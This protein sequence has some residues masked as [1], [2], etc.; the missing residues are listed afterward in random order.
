MLE[1]RREPEIRRSKGHLHRAGSVTRGRRIRP[2]GVDFCLC[3]SEFGLNCRHAIDSSKLR[4][5]SFRERIHPPISQNGHRTQ[6]PGS[7]SFN[8][9][10]SVRQVGRTQGQRG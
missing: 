2:G 1:T 8:A 4:K 9:G 5:L 3:A 7:T 10:A 6:R